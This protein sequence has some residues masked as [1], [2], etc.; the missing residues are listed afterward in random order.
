MFEPKHLKRWTMPSHY[1]GA[2]WPNHYSAG[3]GQSRASDSLE[4]SNFVC[5]LLALGGESDVITV[6]RESHWLVGWV[7][8]IAIEADGTPESDKALAIADDIKRRL[9]D[10]PVI[11]EEHW[12]ETE[13]ED[14]NETWLNCYSWQERI[15]Y[16]HEHR[17]QFEFHDYRD[18]L[19][20]VRGE[21]FAGHASELLS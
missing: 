1:F 8:W 15:K 16:I 19:G 10:Y 4:R 21:Y 20:C 5:M 11:N 18:M 2:T 14:A 17:S 12:S 9:E 3:V 7:E 13:T 6:V